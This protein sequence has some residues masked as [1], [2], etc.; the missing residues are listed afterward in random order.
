M[1]KFATI[2][3][4]ML[5]IFCMF[6]CEKGLVKTEDLSFKE[7]FE[8]QIDKRTHKNFVVDILQNPQGSNNEF[9]A[10]EGAYSVLKRNK[11][12]LTAKFSTKG[13]IPGN[14]YTMWWVLFGEEPGPPVLVTHAAGHVVGKD[15]IG[16]FSAHIKVGGVFN[17]PLTG[18]VH[19]ALRT[20]GPV[21]ADMMPS[22][23]LTI[24]GGC[25]LPEIGYPSGPALYPDSDIVGYCAN[26]QVAMHPRND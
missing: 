25:Q 4:V 22:Q 14:A 26:V 1:K 2:Y 11:K 7:K 15:G 5:S 12:G 8:N 16:N 23:I 19:L 18:E 6:S 10:V 9:I 21:Q 13:L 3:C 17:N 20:H 24:N